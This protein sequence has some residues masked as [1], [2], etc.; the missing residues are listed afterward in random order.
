MTV[1]KSK[2]MVSI[3]ASTGSKLL[4]RETGFNCI[5]SL[6]K[7]GNVN[8]KLRVHVC[9]NHRNGLKIVGYVAHGFNFCKNVKSLD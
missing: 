9:I 4:R 7:Y 2:M 8:N 1:S 3:I 5:Y 6:I